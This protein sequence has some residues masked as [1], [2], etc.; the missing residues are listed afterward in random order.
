[1]ILWNEQ[2]RKGA[3][4]SERYNNVIQMGNKVLFDKTAAF[5]ISAFL[6][7]D[8]SPL[9]FADWETYYFETGEL[10]KKLKTLLPPWLSRFEKKQEINIINKTHG[11]TQDELYFYSRRLKNFASAQGL[12]D[13]EAYNFLYM[14]VLE[15]PYFEYEKEQVAKNWIYEFCDKNG[16]VCVSESNMKKDEKTAYNI[17]KK[18]GEQ[19]IC[20]LFVESTFPLLNNFDN[21]E[22]KEENNTLPIFHLCVDDDLS[23]CD[24]KELKNTI[25]YATG[26]VAKNN[27][28]LKA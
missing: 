18:A 3:F 8:C 25:I 24:E 4:K 10:A 11:K 20:T 19:N 12:S 16:L 21:I 17:I 7:K 6:L 26:L 22:N 9:S 14:S 28:L 2:T 15:K 5:G 13:E 1:M 27:E 23:V